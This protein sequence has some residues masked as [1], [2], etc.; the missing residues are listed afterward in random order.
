M[1]VRS[2]V[3]TR[4]VTDQAPGSGFASPFPMILGGTETL[5]TLRTSASLSTQV[6]VTT[7][8][9]SPGF[10]FSFPVMLGGTEPLRTLRNTSAV[11]S[12]TPK[13]RNM[14]TVKP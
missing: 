13:V 4:P 10:A 7:T 12:F 11:A 6:A 5:R 9:Y 1:T 2:L 3:T 14:E 8:A